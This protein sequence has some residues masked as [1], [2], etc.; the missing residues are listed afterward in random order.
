M[1]KHNTPSITPLWGVIITSNAGYQQEIKKMTELSISIT[2]LDF[3][4]STIC[5]DFMRCKDTNYFP[6]LQMSI[7]K[8]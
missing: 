8:G 3:N 7:P 6:I 2:I 4:I 5:F 1:T